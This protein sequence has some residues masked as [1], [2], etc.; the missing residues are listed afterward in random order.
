MTVVHINGGA[1]PKTQHKRNKFLNLLVSVH[2]KN[3]FIEALNRFLRC[4]EINGLKNLKLFW[5]FCMVSPF[6]YT[7]L[8]AAK[9]FLLLKYH[10]LELA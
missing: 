1:K 7:T 4:F 8:I 9:A 5:G 2:L 6:I 10:K 3:Y